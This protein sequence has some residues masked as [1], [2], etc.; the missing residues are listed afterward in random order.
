MV[1]VDNLKELLPHYVALLLILFAVLG[2]IRLTIGE[3]GIFV[4]LAILLII[5]L[6]YPP[7]VRRLGMAPTAWMRTGKSDRFFK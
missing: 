7:L 6:M 5:S 4:E 3:L 2:A 1:D